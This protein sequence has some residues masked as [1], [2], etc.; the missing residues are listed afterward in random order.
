MLKPFS[1]LPYDLIWRTML[2]AFQVETKVDRGYVCC[3]ERF[4]FSCF[5]SCN[6]Q[7]LRGE[8]DLPLQ[9][10]FCPQFIRHITSQWRLLG[11]SRSPTTTWAVWEALFT[12]YMNRA[13]KMQFA[14][15][16][17][18]R[19]EWK[20][21]YLGKRER[22]DVVCVCSAFLFEGNSR[23]KFHT[24]GNMFNCFHSSVYDTVEVPATS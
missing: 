10:Q 14:C 9:T 18:M 7:E 8:R 5:S 2:C 19:L 23:Q 22:K 17:L 1:S 21:T 3:F 6:I 20:F 4:F 12:I 16:L 24:L 15:D 11:I 13:D